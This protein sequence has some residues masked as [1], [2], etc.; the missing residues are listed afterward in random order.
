MAIIINANREGYGIDQIRNTMTVGELIDALSDFDEDTPVYI[1]ND[2]QSY[3]WYT[4]G[5][6]TMRDIEETDG[7]EEEDD[8]R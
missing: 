8:E 3:G 6:I 5:S 7:E 2:R 4:Y 1:G